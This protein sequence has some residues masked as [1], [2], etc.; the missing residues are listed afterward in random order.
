MKNPPIVV[1]KSAMDL[2]RHAKGG[3]E[4]LTPDQA[5]EELTHGNIVLID[6]READE[7]RQGHIAGAIHASRG[8]LEFYADSSLPYHKAEFDK[9]KRL[10]LYCASGGRSALAAETLEDMGYANVAHID[11]GIKAWQ[12]ANLPISN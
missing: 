6:V 2:V 3:I 8:M 12:A 10:I 4:N 1:A 7:Y 9:A 5:N 11:G